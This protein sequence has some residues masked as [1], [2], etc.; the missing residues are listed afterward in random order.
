MQ[1][2]LIKR[3]RNFNRVLQQQIQIVT[4][5]VATVQLVPIVLNFSEREYD[6]VKLSIF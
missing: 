3:V 6:L 1:L 4:K 2:G 5:H